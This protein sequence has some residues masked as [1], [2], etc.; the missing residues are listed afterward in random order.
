MPKLLQ[1]Y[2]EESAEYRLLNTKNTANRLLYELK[3]FK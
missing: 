1:N 3:S 2:G